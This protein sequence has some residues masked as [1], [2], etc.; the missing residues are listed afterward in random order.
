[1]NQ[2]LKLTPAQHRAAMNLLRGLQ[3]GDVIVLEGEPGTGKT[4]ILQEV[5]RQAGGKLL[6]VRDFLEALIARGPAAIEE[7]FLAMLDAAVAGH[8]LVLVD[9]LHLVANIVEDC[10]YPRSHL[11]DAALTAVLGEAAA[12]GKKL[13][14]ATHG[15]APWPVRR[16]AITWEI[17]AY[18]AEDYRCLCEAGS[19]RRR[20]ARSITLGSIASPRC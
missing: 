1:M 18:T 15:E 3:V 2:E 19:I 8:D 10:E 7:A 11:L 17:R 13:V 20:P 5:H 6:G 12:Q 14:F 4:T 16:R 9:D